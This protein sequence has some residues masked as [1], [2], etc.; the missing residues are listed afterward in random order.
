[1]RASSVDADDRDWQE[2]I[3]Q[4]PVD[5]HDWTGNHANVVEVPEAALADLR[6]RRPTV[7]D[8]LEADAITLIG[9]SVA[10]LLGGER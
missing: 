9:P 4:L 6:R 5:I 10:K 7:V 3:G 2:Q 1:V 8:S